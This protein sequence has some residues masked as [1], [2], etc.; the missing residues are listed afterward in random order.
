MVETEGNFRWTRGAI[1]AT[2][3]P[4][5]RR[6]G[7]VSAVDPDVRGRSA[8]TRKRSS[9]AGDRCE[10]DRPADRRGRRA[11]RHHPG[12]C[13]SSVGASRD[14]D[15]L[16]SKAAPHRRRWLLFALAAVTLALVAVVG[17]IGVRAC[18]VKSEL[19]ALSPLAEAAQTATGDADFRGVSAI[20]T[21]IERH[22]ERAPRAFRADPVWR[23][24]EALPGVG[25]NLRAVRVVSVELAA[26]AGAVS[27]R[28]R[29]SARSRRRASGP[30]VDIEALAAATGSLE[31]LA[32]AADMPPQNSGRSTPMPW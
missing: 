13:S 27:R 22:A 2:I 9:T 12:S 32:A 24:A 29:S 11:R 20:V 10:R 28:S 23:A 6:A 14:A 16:S 5:R 7:L 19:D 17:W 31:H 15:M 25:E 4:V 21:D 30:V 3:E 26:V 8:R 18:S 1:T